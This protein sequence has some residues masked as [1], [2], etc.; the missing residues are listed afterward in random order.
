M[1]LTALI[2][3]GIGLTGG[4]ASSAPDTAKTAFAS[5]TNLT[6]TLADSHN[7]NLKWKN[8]AT[9][10][11]GNFV[12]ALIGGGSNFVTL[13]I[14]GSDVDSYRHPNLAPNT[15]FV[16]RIHPF[17]GRVSNTVEVTTGKAPATPSNEADALLDTKEDLSTGA[18]QKKSIKTLATFAKAAPTKLSATLTS[19]TIAVLKW[20]DHA[21]DEDGYLVE[22]A[23]N[24]NGRFQ[25][26]ALLPPHAASFRVAGLPPETKCDFRV[27]AFFYGTCSNLASA[28]IPD[29]PPPVLKNISN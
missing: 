14:V 16:Y 1:A 19:P 20:V 2:T 4:M 23:P 28:A 5:P 25:A 10:P 8:H 15:K 3:E 6:A 11:F 12:E 18:A 17:Y 13:A 29:G 24:A 21:S 9:E 7:I 26:I 22:A 27:R